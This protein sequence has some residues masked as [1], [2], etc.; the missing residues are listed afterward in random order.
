M[1]AQRSIKH[2]FMI[3][4]A[5]LSLLPAFRAVAMTGGF[6]AASGRLGVSPSAVSQSVRQLE[7]HLGI[8]LFDRTSRHVRLTEAGA[9]LFDGAAA[10]LDL[11]GDLVA[12]IRNEAGR[13][14]G[15]LRITLS[16]L[17]AEICILEKLPAFT[18]AYPEIELELNTNDAL[19]DIVASGFDA[20][21]RLRHS[22]DAD[23]IA[24]PIGPELRRAMLATPDYLV[25]HGTPRFPQELM[26]HRLIR[27]RFPG[28]QNLEPLRFQIE[29]ESVAV[30]P[31]TR[32]VLTDNR[33]I[34]VAVRAGLG[35]S[36]RFRVT[37]EDA[38]ASGALK[39]VLGDY[40]PEPSRFF[41]YYPSK[42]YQS[43]TL[44]LFLDW[45]APISSEAERR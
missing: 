17:A 19:V 35:L 3:D 42:A 11:L 31:P 33:D 14:A 32:L 16:R 28:R 9:Q 38:I 24:R 37:E 5:V 25:E 39:V 6:T 26:Q 41:I 36:Q 2:C 22:L 45:F 1:S 43:R 27:Y 7:K 10:S 12:H 34:S 13:P 44:T 15:P 4:P 29:G 40:E 30:D 23:M 20:G 18:R 8:R 21:I